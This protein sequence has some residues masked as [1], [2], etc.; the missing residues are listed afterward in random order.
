MTSIFHHKSHYLSLDN[1]N[2]DENINYYRN[3]DQPASRTTNE[4]KLKKL[5]NTLSCKNCEW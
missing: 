5:I 1:H 4:I 2:F 3:C